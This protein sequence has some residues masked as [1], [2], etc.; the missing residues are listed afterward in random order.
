MPARGDFMPYLW[1]GRVYLGRK[2]VAKASR[3]S[4]K[5]VAWHLR[6]YG[7]L[8]RLGV[9]Q[10]RHS[11]EKP[12]RTPNCTPVNIGKASWPSKRA[13]AR[14]AGLPD[15][16]L[17]RKL[18]SGDPETLIAVLMAATGDRHGTVG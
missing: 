11:T 18:K 2:A 17:R 7:H 4:I 3:T 10:G 16:T 14:A 5:T 6:A 13:L 8:D 1:R 9:G 15:T 12:P